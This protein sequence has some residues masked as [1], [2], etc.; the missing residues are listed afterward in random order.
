IFFFQ[1]GDGIR[2]FH[3][4]GVQTCAL[5]IL[6]FLQLFH[7]LVVHFEQANFL[8]GR[9]VFDVGRRQAQQSEDRID[10]AVLQLGGGIAEAV[11]ERSSEE[12]RVGKER[13][14]VGAEAPRRQPTAG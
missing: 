8:G 2:V 7:R 10:L 12:R 13:R 11:V 1:A 6:F 4:T 9:D 5:P 3:V 14:W